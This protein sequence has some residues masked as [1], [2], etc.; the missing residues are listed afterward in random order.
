MVNRLLYRI[1]QHVQTSA[2]KI[3]TVNWSTGAIVPAAKYC[4]C[5]ENSVDLQLY[6]LVRLYCRGQTLVAQ[7]AVKQRE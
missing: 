1:E 5:D 6:H 3:C 7:P 2:V 4:E